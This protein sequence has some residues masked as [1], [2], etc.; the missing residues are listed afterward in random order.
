[1]GVL[2]DYNR[3]LLFFVLLFLSGSVNAKR[4]IP[5]TPPSVIE[6]GVEYSV[7]TKQGFVEARDTETGEEIWVRE[8]FRVEYSPHFEADVQSVHIVS[9]L[10]R[11]GEL[12]LL[13]DRGAEYKMDLKT[14]VCSV[15]DGRIAPIV[16]KTDSAVI[17]NNSGSE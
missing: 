14:G 12:V 8:L 9:L 15:G 16:Y 1:M 3:F 13:D 6:S 2:K 4:V 7:S 5:E 11:D 17:Q 10:I